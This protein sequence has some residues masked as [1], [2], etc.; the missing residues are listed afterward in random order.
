MIGIE[1]KSGSNIGMNDFRYMKWFKETLVADRPFSGIILYS[2]ENVAAF[3]ESMHAVP[4]GMLW[5]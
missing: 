5:S 1:I 3:G 4:F 2:G